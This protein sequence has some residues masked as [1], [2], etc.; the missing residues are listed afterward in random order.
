MIQEESRHLF[1]A[2]DEKIRDRSIVDI[3]ATDK[4]SDKS[5][6]SILKKDNNSNEVLNYLNEVWTC[7]SVEGVFSYSGDGTPKM[8]NIVRECFDKIAIT[9]PEESREP[10]KQLARNFLALPSLDLVLKLADFLGKDGKEVWG[11]LDEAK[12]LW[13]KRAEDI[14]VYS[15]QYNKLFKIVDDGQYN[16]D[17]LKKKKVPKQKSN[18][19]EAGVNT[20]RGDYN[21]YLVVTSA[22]EKDR[23]RREARNMFSYLLTLDRRARLKSKIYNKKVDETEPSKQIFENTRRIMTLLLKDPSISCDDSMSLE[24]QYN[25][26]IRMAEIHDAPRN[27]KDAFLKKFGGV[28]DN[29]FFEEFNKINGEDILHEIKLYKFGNDFE[30]EIKAFKELVKIVSDLSVD[31]PKYI[32]INQQFLTQ[33]KGF[34]AMND[35]YYD[36]S[37]YY[38][39]YVKVAKDLINQY[40]E[41]NK[42][43]PEKLLQLTDYFEYYLTLE[44]PELTRIINKFYQGKLEDIPT[45][46]ISWKEML[47]TKE[48]IILDLKPD[49]PNYNI[50]YKGL[51]TMIDEYFENRPSN[52]P[53]MKETE[54]V[55]IILLEK[56]FI[57]NKGKEER[58]RGI[59]PNLNACVIFP[60]ME[61]TNLVAD[62]ILVEDKYKGERANYLLVTWRAWK[63]RN[64]YDNYARLVE[65][66]EAKWQVTSLRKTISDIR[67]RNKWGL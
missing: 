53:A 47:M 5:R 32:E 44:N 20:G 42:G 3:G 57:D 13:M 16:P 54:E 65:M 62:G 7:N 23:Q 1:M 36:S 14:P 27:T 10:Y 35:Y 49:D 19:N 9:V 43:D 48:S 41:K 63:A 24:E 55:L 22:G 28:N 45:E 50:P 46:A 40:Y 11:Y 34:C 38:N 61:L 26:L 21:D 15:G 2:K 4:W 60:N 29:N 12:K 31:D 52:D 59:I 8:I 18:T 51:L 17:G 6:L 58:I 37:I 30:S 67:D 33:F 25:Y 66:F 64:I 39:Q 56:Y